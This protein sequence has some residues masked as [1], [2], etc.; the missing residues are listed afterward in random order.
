MGLTNL[1]QALEKKMGLWAGEMKDR[2]KKVAQILSLYESLPEHRT[3]VDHLRV[4]LDCAGEVMRDDRSRVV[5]GDAQAF[6]ASR[7]QE[8]CEA[9]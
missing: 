8:R 2:E 9:W 1:K 7:P 4:V 6:Q 5:S 3:R